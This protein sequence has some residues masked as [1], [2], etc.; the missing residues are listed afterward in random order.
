LISYIYLW[1]AFML[2]PL[3]L[4]LGMVGAGEGGR[5]GGREGGG[6]AKEK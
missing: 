3:N 4:Q 2:S 5:E 1:F 6:M